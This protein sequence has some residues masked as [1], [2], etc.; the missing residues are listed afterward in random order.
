MSGSDEKLGQVTQAL[1]APVMT[2]KSIKTLKDVFKLASN[3]IIAM[4]NVKLMKMGGIFQSLHV[5]SVAKSV[6]VEDKC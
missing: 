4:I 5:N 1:S 2:F 3:D 6:I